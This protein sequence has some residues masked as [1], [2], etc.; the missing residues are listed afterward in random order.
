ME[1]ERE[2]GTRSSSRRNNST[3]DA[4]LVEHSADELEGLNRDVLNAEITQLEGTITFHVFRPVP[5]QIADRTFNRPAEELGRMKPNLN[6]LAEYRK[7]ESEF[8]DRAR[9]LD[10]VTKD[11]DHAKQQYDD[12]RKTRLEE[13]MVGFSIISSKLKEMYQVCVFWTF[14]PDCN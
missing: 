8:L 1:D 14:V 13:F 5:L 6:V 7:R 3:E 11:R 12:L 9:D 2:E 4:Q 10:M